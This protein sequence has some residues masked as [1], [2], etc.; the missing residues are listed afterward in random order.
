MVGGALLLSRHEVESR[1]PFERE[2]LGGFS[3]RPILAGFVF[4][5]V[6]VIVFAWL[7]LTI[8]DWY[9][10]GP[11]LTIPTERMPARDLTISIVWAVY[12]LCLLAL[13][14]AAV[15]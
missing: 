10:S 6:V 3:P 15:D 11:A 12:A 13:G 8:F 9:A 5:G 1:A 4:G 2:A 14:M 7:N